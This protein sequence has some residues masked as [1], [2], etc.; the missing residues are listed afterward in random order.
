[1]DESALRAR[2]CKDTTLVLGDVGR[3]VPELVNSGTLPPIGFAALDLDLYSSTAQALRILSLPGARILRRVPLYFDDV[4]FAFN[5][6][7]AGELLA[8]EEFNAQ[9][10]K[11][12]IDRWHGVRHGRPFP[13]RPYLGSMYMAH[14]LA[15][16]PRSLRSRPAELPLPCR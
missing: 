13:E 10:A 11:I 15:A 4:H 5:H 9:N 3:T 6:R 2:L 14:D 16:P 7:F 1:M 8:I 12:K